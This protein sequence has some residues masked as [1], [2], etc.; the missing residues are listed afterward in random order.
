MYERFSDRARTVMRLANQEAEQRG[1]QFIGPEH[2]FLGLLDNRS[3]MAAHLLQTVGGGV[4]RLRD[5]IG[6]LKSPE[7]HAPDGIPET[8]RAKA[9]IERSIEEARSLNHEFVGTQ[10]VLL[11]IL[12]EPNKLL[13]AAFSATGLDA[14]LVR[15]HI[16]L[17]ITSNVCEDDGPPA[18]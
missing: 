6:R 17:E 18:A 10:H 11:A 5:E 13:S 7:P 4:E 1:E 3:G 12:R 9:V 14:R 16:L 8:P 15:E 2:I